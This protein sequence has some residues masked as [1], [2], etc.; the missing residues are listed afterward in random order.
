MPTQKSSTK[1][2]VS[3]LVARINTRF[4]KINR[5]FL[6][7]SKYHTNKTK[8]ARNLKKMTLI[9]D[10]FHN[11]ERGFCTWFDSHCCHL[12][13]VFRRTNRW[14]VVWCVLVVTFIHS[15]IFNDRQWFCFW[16]QDYRISGLVI[17]SNWYLNKQIESDYK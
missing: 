4:L 3:L 8:P 5:L 7:P 14:F 16:Q 12:F 17:S 1:D 9:N 10:A 13:W 6:L 11:V 2:G 15:T